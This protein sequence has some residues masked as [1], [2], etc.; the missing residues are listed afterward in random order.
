MP[1]D[2]IPTLDRKGLRHFGWLLGA[3]LPAVFGLLIPWLWGLQRVPV[4][5]WFAVGAVF[6]AWASIA[7]QTLGGVYYVW[8]RMALA[9]GKVVNAVILALVFFL[10]I[11]PMGVVMRWSG[12]DPLR[13]K[14]DHEADSYRVESKAA[15]REQVEKPY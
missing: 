7:P 9:I 12:R 8:M 14:I 11:T 13:R 4:W 10:V 3:F 5:E 1:G 2:S 15:A 6:L